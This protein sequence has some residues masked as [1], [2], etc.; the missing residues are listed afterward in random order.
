M[1]A[2]L[3]LG[4]WTFEPTVTLG[5]VALVAAYVIAVRRGRLR[6]D[7]DV[8]PWLGSTRWRAWMFGLGVLTAFLALESPVD[9]GGD[10]YLLSLHMV[11]HLV[12]MMVSPPLV[13][14]GICGM[15]PPDPARAPGLRRLWT[16]STRP[17]PAT[18]LFNAV[19]LVWHIP[20]LY[21]TTL[22]NEAAHIVEHITFVA[23]GVVLW[24]A[25]VDPI[26]GEGTTPISPFQKIAALAVAG[27]PP[28]VLGLIFSVASNPF[29]EFYARAPR[30]WGL[31]PVTDQQVAGV[32]MF[33]LGNLIYFAAI[34]VIFWRILGNPADDDIEAVAPPFMG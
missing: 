6:R 16:A 24:W 10:N 22:R 5:L 30:L 34:S 11:Q 26:R 12:L 28:T 31:S 27:V 13:L 21:D 25:V 32:V 14:L 15:R 23:V 17:L 1:K 9:T 18:V 33:G 19:L 29:Y 8:S 4:D 2:S 20:T 3:G 7:D